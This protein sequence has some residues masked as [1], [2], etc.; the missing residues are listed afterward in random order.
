MLWHTLAIFGYVIFSGCHSFSEIK[1]LYEWT[2]SILLNS[3][4]I[5][6][7]SFFNRF[8]ESA[9]T[10]MISL[11]FEA[12]SFSP[13]IPWPLTGEITDQISLAKIIVP[14]LRLSFE[15]VERDGGKV[16]STG[17]LLSNQ[18]KTKRQLKMA[19]RCIKQ[20]GGRMKHKFVV[21]IRPFSPATDPSLTSL[22]TL[23]LVMYSVKFTVFSINKWTSQFAN[24]LFLLHGLS[25]YPERP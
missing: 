21:S 8:T 2:Y 20:K 23:G 9:E 12:K 18:T 15:G 6:L 3:S 7:L 17:F 11:G 13:S 22:T 16:A 1:L 5:C 25:V 24:Q 14:K 19:S 10:R 4:Q